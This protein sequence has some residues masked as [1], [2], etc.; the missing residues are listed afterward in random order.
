M[1]DPI[2]DHRLRQSLLVRPGNFSAM[3]FQFLSPPCA[4][5]V[6][7]LKSECRA[8][9]ITGNTADRPDEVGKRTL[10]VPFLP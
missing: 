2:L 9:M 3:T 8:D 1:F 5:K 7:V 4:S 10:E 6:C